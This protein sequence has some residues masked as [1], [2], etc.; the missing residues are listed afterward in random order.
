MRSSIFIIFTL[1]GLCSYGQ[2]KKELKAQIA[3]LT[4]EKTQ[5]EQE[6]LNEKKEKETIK[7]RLN[8][9]SNIEI[10][11][12]ITPEEQPKEIKIGEEGWRVDL[13]GTKYKSD[14]LG[15]LG[16]IWILDS[17]NQ[18]KPQGAIL[19]SDYK[20]EPTLISKEKDVLYK[21]FISKGTTLQGDGGAP[22]AKITAGLTMDQFSDFSISI[23]GTSQIKPKFSD[24]RKIG[25]EINELFDLTNAKGIFL[26]TGMHVVQYY[27]RI[28]SK[29]E[30]DGKITSPVVNIGG[31]FYA[32]NNEESKEYFVARQ[33]TQIFR[34]SNKDTTKLIADIQSLI[35]NSSNAQVQANANQYSP[36]EI[37]TFFLK[38]QPTT[39]EI[40][41]FQNNPT[42]FMGKLDLGHTITGKEKLLL[43][44]ADLK[45]TDVPNQIKSI[46]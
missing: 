22:F 38:R 25:K 37:L 17:T 44:T 30:G 23:D 42:E 13:N 4:S 10:D 39:D 6:V 26:C 46:H 33:L 19:L 24:L 11:E 43:N 35:T 34:A 16:T 21:K 7:T 29:S 41:S 32:E 2:S 12:V 3:K 40:L 27:A 15:Q 45:I 8:R 31:S 36:Q 1:F 18:L 20:I 28:Y 5:A 14:I 9:I